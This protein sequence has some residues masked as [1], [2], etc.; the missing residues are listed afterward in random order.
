[1]RRFDATVVS[2]V[3][4]V[5]L[6]R[7]AFYPTGGG[8][9]CDIGKLY[10]NGI[11]IQVIEVRK[12]GDDI[13]HLTNGDFYLPIGSKVSGEINWERRYAHM[14]H[15]TLLHIIDG[16]VEKFYGGKVTGGQIYQDKARMDFDVPMMDKQKA[17]NIIAKAQE[18]VDEGHNVVQK[19]LTKEEAA[20]IQNLSRTLPG[21][22]LLKKL[23]TIRVIDIE[24]F[25]MQLDGGTHVANTKEVGNIKLESYESRGAHNKRVV[26]SSNL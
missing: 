24:G 8:Q 22:E 23:D 17:E 13:L 18:I 26:V 11:E 1:M 3:N 20:S 10:F 9:P 4:G 2:V 5:V 6:D 19:I 7:T 12:N 15:H 14:R 25:D 21:N 16:V